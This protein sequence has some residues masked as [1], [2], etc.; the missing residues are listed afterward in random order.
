MEFTLSHCMYPQVDHL[1]VELRKA[2][3]LAAAEEFYID[4]RLVANILV[5]Y[6]HGHPS[7]ARKYYLRILV[8]LVIYDSG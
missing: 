7:P 4:R 3:M 8:Y 5:S 1:S 6:F 2:R